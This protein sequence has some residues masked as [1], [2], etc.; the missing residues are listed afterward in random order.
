MVHDETKEKPV[1]YKEYENGKIGCLTLHRPENLN[2]VNEDLLDA[3]HQTLGKVASNEKLSILILHSTLE[4]AFCAGGDVKEIQ[5]KSNEEAARFFEK[6]ATVLDTI[7]KLPQLTIAAINGI[8]FGAGAD[9]AIACDYRIG[10]SKTKIKFPGPQFGVI[11]GTHRLVNEIGPSKAR[12]LVLTNQL[13]DTEQSLHHGLLH[14]ISEEDDSFN[15]AVTRAQAML[16]MTDYT[17]RELVKIC[18]YEEEVHAGDPIAL[19]KESV[20]QGNFQE[21]FS[22]YVE[23]VKK[24]K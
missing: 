3:L 11:L 16:H 21:R 2:A 24:K 20:L 12:H 14:E 22:Q 19:A 5:T 6:L 15:T 1:L 4:K 18:S 9:L 17:R 13:M 7:T 23:T 8:A 10:N